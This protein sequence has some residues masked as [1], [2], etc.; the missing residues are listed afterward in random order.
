M[1]RES[2]GWQSAILYRRTLA[3]GTTITSKDWDGRSRWMVAWTLAEWNAIIR[4][5]GK[6]DVFG[7]SAP[8][9]CDRT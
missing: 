6:T 8:D 7:K 5:L 1:G 2:K 9:M 3:I 4:N